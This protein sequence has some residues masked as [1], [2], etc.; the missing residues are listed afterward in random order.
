[1]KGRV[2]ASFAGALA[3]CLLLSGMALSDVNAANAI[4]TSAKCSVEFHAPT[5]DGFGELNNLEIP[6]FLYKVA[7]VDVSGKYSSLEAFQELGLEQVNSETTAKEWEEKAEKAYAVIAGN[8]DQADG[9]ENHK[10]Q[11]IPQTASIKNGLGTATEIPVGMY[12]VV[13]E[14]VQSPEY[15]YSFN[16]YLL[17]LPNNYYYSNQ[18]DDWVYDVKGASLKPEKKERYG[19][20]VIDKTLKTYNATLGRATFVF[21]VEGKKTDGTAYSNVASIVF[22]QAGTA[23]VRLDQIPAGMEVTVK[24]VYSGA[25]YE[26]DSNEEVTA[27]IVADEEAHVGFSNEHNGKMN[28]GASVVNHFTKNEKEY[29]DVTQIPDTK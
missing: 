20:L 2:K 18:T 1:M 7:D 9:E 17:A 10:I 4:D 19:S 24:E 3:F 12:L 21:Q 14:T 6:V 29:W 16:P 13:A 28:G 27:K 22:D 25:S 26:L 15:E 23:S 5:E 8:E 11:P